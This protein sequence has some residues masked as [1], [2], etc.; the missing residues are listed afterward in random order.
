MAQLNSTKNFL[1]YFIFLIIS[2]LIVIVSLILPKTFYSKAEMIQATCG[3]PISFTIN[4]RSQW[5][6][7]FPWKTNCF[8]SPWE[9]IHQIL[10]LQLIIDLVIVFSFLLIIFY[11]FQIIYKK[12]FVKG[13][14][15]TE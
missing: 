5:S 15:K 11:V 9:D 13:T 2:F 7:P 14:I 1:V 10:W 8:G 4:D 12:R 3:L 6:P